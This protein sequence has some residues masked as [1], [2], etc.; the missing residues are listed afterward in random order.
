MISEKHAEGPGPNPQCCARTRHRNSTRQALRQPQEPV[1]CLQT[2]SPMASHGLPFACALP[3]S[4]HLAPPV[5]PVRLAT[6]SMKTALTAS[7][8][9]LLC[10]SPHL[11]H[12]FRLCQAGPCHTEGSCGSTQAS[13]WCPC[14]PAVPTAPPPRPR[15]ACVHVGAS[16]HVLCWQAEEERGECGPVK[17]WK[18]RV[19]ATGAPG[20]VRAGRSHGGEDA[21]PR[22][23]PASFLPLLPGPWEQHTRPHRVPSARLRVHNGDKSSSGQ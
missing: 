15:R 18:N 4:A 17:A 8:I 5:Y 9:T 3:S 14:T 19:R 2:V 22:P 21:S 10:A 12:C 23:A 11:V 20:H 6:S 16:L 7:Q 1:P 13:L